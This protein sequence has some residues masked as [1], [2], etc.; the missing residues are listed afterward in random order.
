MNS[1]TWQKLIGFVTGTKTL[2]FAAIAIITLVNELRLN[3]ATYEIKESSQ[4]LIEE[5]YTE[6]NKTIKKNRKLDSLNTISFIQQLSLD[7]GVVVDYSLIQ[8]NTKDAVN[9]GFND[10]LA[11]QTM[12]MNVERA[13]YD[14]L[15]YKTPLGRFY[16]VIHSKYADTVNK[17]EII[18]FLPKGIK[19]Q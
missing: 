12:L 18:D 9:R 2:V 19:S 13:K 8:E 7:N 14:T 17:I 4:D 3:V 1:L 15:Y 5:Q 11:H 6:L 16:R 10:A